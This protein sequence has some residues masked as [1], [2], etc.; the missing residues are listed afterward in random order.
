MSAIHRR[1]DASVRA[2]W[3]APFL[4]VAIA[5]VKTLVGGCQH[6]T[7]LICLVD[8]TYW[9]CKKMHSES[10]IG[11]VTYQQLSFMQR[12]DEHLTAHCFQKSQHYRFIPFADNSYG[13]ILPY[14]AGNVL[15]IVS[16]LQAR[17]L[18]KRLA[19]LH[20]LSD[21]LQ[22]A[23][24]FPKI[25]LARDEAT[26]LWVHEWAKA[27]NR[28]ITAHKSEWVIAHRD[29]NLSNIIWNDASFPILIDWESAGW[30]HPTVDLIGLA[31][32]C[33]L[34]KNNLFEIENF[35]AVLEGYRHRNGQLPRD[36][37]D[38]WIMMGH[39]WLL[40]YSYV[41]NHNWRDQATQCLQ[42]LQVLKNLLPTLR[43][44][45]NSASDPM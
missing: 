28:R 16:T 36:H 41:L 29:L 31:V 33:A 23:E 18:G 21:F 40:W 25:A 38:F 37:D 14:Q 10:W 20:D 13:I 22:G 45:Y 43:Q 8:G 32:N 4:G 24:P 27:C 17:L 3:S 39:S 1:A 26:P 42:T 5:C 34:K 19:E 7:D 35:Q 15:S 12:L 44:F 30:I 11:P 6:Q 2:H 9:V